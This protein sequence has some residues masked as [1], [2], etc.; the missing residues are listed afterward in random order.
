MKTSLSISKESKK[1]AW[2]EEH[3][4]PFNEILKKSPKYEN[5][6]RQF[7]NEIYLTL[8]L[9]ADQFS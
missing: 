7:L 3:G 9:I 1:I 5:V 8:F 4:K 6:I 2:T